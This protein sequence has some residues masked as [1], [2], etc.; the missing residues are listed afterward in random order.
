MC[1]ILGNIWPIPDF[2][3]RFNKKGSCL[4][5]VIKSK[6]YQQ[7]R[8]PFPSNFYVLQ[9][10][11][12]RIRCEK[13]EVKFKQQQINH[14]KQKNTNTNFWKKALDLVMNELF[15]MLSI[16]HL[17]LKSTNVSYRAPLHLIKNPLDYY[18]S[19]PKIHILGRIK[20]RSNKDSNWSTKIA[21]KIKH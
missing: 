9:Q 19:S 3:M 1:P 12:I 20:S 10:I 11:F 18:V 16:V 8:K 15:V 14:L 4:F 5:V 2:G 13:K 21:D 6:R 7:K 17:S